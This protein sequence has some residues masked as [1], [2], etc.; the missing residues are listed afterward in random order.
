MAFLVR[1]VCNGVKEFW[2]A[3]HELGG[4]D[5]DSEPEIVDI[6]TE[7]V[8]LPSTVQ[9]RRVP[10]PKEPDFHIQLRKNSQQICSRLHALPFFAV[11][12]AGTLSVPRYAQYLRDL[13]AIHSVLEQLQPGED[14][15]V[16]SIFFPVLFRANALKEDLAAWGGEKLSASADVA[17]YLAKLQQE[18]GQDPRAL[19]GALYVFY[20][21]ILN[22]ETLVKGCVEELF[23]RSG[24]SAS[25]SGAQYYALPFGTD[26]A[27]LREIR[28]QAIDRLPLP[29]NAV[30]AQELVAIGSRGCLEAYTILYAVRAAAC[31]YTQTT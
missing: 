18:V 10:S 22:G 9:E 13:Y 20:G 16:R 28:H 21:E 5:A 15:T 1:A 23:K 14:A 29:Y 31:S 17:Q 27:K 4:Y 2:G 19:I 8:S 7:I 25:T 30:T 3:R 6:E 11:L 12:R 26:L 24:L